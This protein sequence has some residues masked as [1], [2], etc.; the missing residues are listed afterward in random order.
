MRSAA[1]GFV[2]AAGLLVGGWVTGDRGELCTEGG[3]SRDEL[4]DGIGD[5]GQVAGG[6]C[7]HAA[8]VDVIDDGES[9]LGLGAREIDAECG[10]C[11]V[12]LFRDVL[13]REGGI[14]K[15]IDE[16]IAELW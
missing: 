16:L 4:S 1:G 2:A 13:E 15:E 14:G 6:N 10:E 3:G 9:G 5:G 7:A 11:G 8:C 12:E